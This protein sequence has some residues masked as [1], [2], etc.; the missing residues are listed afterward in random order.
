MLREIE[1]IFEHKQLVDLE[2]QNKLKR[3]REREILGTQTNKHRL[4]V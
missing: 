4:K 2:T 3:E 1:M